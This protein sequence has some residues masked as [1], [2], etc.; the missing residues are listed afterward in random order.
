[1]SDEPT[2]KQALLD[3]IDERWGALQALVSAL[4][5]ADMERP[6]GDGWSARVHFAHLT[7]WERSA[8]GLLRKQHRG[9]AMGLPRSLWDAHDQGDEA[10]WAD[11]GEAVNAALAATAET[12]PLAEV[13][14]QSAST[15]AELL[16]LLGSLTQED[17]ER[18][19]SHYQP[20]DPP[21]NPAPV[22]G[23]VHGNT[24]SHYNEHIG[25]LEAGLKS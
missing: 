14:A 7:A 3:R 25:W 2:S 19:Y 8:I 18:P 16:A 20:D 4:S 9:D 5:P 10:T 13:L 22:V 15:H 11:T 24:W 17:L 21:F 12:Q 1:M 23:W 6:L